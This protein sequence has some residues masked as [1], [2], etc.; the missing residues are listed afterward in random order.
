VIG[1]CSFFVTGRH[2]L[3]LRHSLSAELADRYIEFIYF[4]LTIIINLRRSIP[5]WQS[6]LYY[7]PNCC[8]VRAF[9]GRVRMKP[10]TDCQP[11]GQAD[12]VA[13]QHFY[14][15]SI[16]SFQF[17]VLPTDQLPVYCLLPIC[18]WL[19]NTDETW[20]TRLMLQRWPTPQCLC[21]KV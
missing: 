20:C 2:C 13:D 9:T 6:G 4:F 18:W 11:V 16:T 14:Y 5:I 8:N 19:E 21:L 12:W 1:N 3:V 15:G 7:I 17:I 10:L